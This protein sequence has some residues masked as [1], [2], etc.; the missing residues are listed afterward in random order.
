MN[1]HSAKHIHF[2]GISG[3]GIS[4]IAKWALDNQKHVTGSDLK[5]SLVSAWLIKQGAIINIGPHKES[6]LCIDCDLVIY[7]VAIT[8]DN[9]ELQIAK[10]KKIA[11]LTYPQA[12]AQL[13]LNKQGIAIAGTHGKSTTTAI[14]AEILVQ[15]KR[16][17]SVIVG[18]RVRQ[19]GNTN[20]RFGQGEDFLIEA[21]EYKRAF[22][23]Y[24]PKF[25]AVLNVEWDHVDIYPTLQDVVESFEVFVKRIPSSG[26]LVL[27]AQDK[28][29][30]TLKNVSKAKIISFGQ[31][32]ADIFST[33]ISTNIDGMQF[34]INGLYEGIIK[35]HLFG[36][37]NVSNILAACALASA[38]EI[39]FLIVQK[40]VNDFPGTW[41]RFEYRGEWKGVK[42]ID[43]YAHHPTEIRATL[44]AARDA[45]PNKKIVC[46]FQPHQ[47]SRTKALQADFIN[48]LKLADQQIILE[49]YEVAGRENTE[50]VSSRVISDSLGVTS[51]F[52]LDIPS[53]IKLAEKIITPDCILLTLGAGDITTFYDLAKKTSP[54][55]EARIQIKTSEGA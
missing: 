5:R 50:H 13:M 51:N 52:A 43:D 25:A 33:N 26:T 47:G 48:A 1:L 9:P 36:N 54:I 19:F 30:E 2:I 4:A 41:R 40:A 8:D 11:L 55:D 6:N 28:Y 27:N 29:F 20:E 34:I 16:D 3:I 49:T 42:V 46:I 17:P 39:P 21:D 23:N 32:G 22:H 14:L 31:T 12:V 53:G 38:L 24:S 7:S 15:A 18:T 10:S 37:H 44:I 35:T 45:F